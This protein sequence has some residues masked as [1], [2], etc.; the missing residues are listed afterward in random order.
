MMKA[1][2]LNIFLLGCAFLPLYGCAGAKNR[3]VTGGAWMQD[4]IIRG[5]NIKV[6]KKEAIDNYLIIQDEEQKAFNQEREK[7]I[8]NS[9]NQTDRI[10]SDSLSSRFDDA[11]FASIDVIEKSKPIANNPSLCLKKAATN[12]DGKFNFALTPDEVRNGYSYL[13]SDYYE[14]EYEWKSDLTGR[15]NTDRTYHHW[16]VKIP[17]DSDKINLDINEANSLRFIDTTGS[18]LSKT[19]P[20][21]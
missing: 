4:N 3:E 15:I 6:C 20:D 17:S 1:I 13:W 5:L 9:G 19:K 18:G 8:N 2:V 21:L 10:T 14:R 7:K 11:K 16:I 12:I